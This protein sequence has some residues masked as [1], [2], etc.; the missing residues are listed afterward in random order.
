MRCVIKFST[1]FLFGIG[2]KIADGKA[3][4][5]AGVQDGHILIIDTESQIKVWVDN[6]MPDR[7]KEEYHDDIVVNDNIKLKFQQQVVS[8]VFQTYADPSLLSYLMNI[9]EREN[10]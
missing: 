9:A 6:R 8:S 5:I 10:I 2:N 3:Y 7:F 1:P 4:K